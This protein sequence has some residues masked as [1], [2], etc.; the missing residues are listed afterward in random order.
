VGVWSGL[1]GLGIE[2]VSD[3]CECGKGYINAGNFS[4]GCNPVSFSRRTL[5]HGVSE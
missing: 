4:T 3:T 1:G 5:L 2:R